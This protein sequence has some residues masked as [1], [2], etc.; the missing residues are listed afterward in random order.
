MSKW[1]KVAPP[2][3]CWHVHIGTELFTP[4]YWLSSSVASNELC[5]CFNASPNASPR[6]ETWG[7]SAEQHNPSATQ[8]ALTSLCEAL[9]GE[10]SIVPQH[11]ECDGI[12]HLQ[13]CTG[14]HLL[15]NPVKQY[16]LDTRPKCINLKKLTLGGNHSHVNCILT[17][18]P[19][20]CQNGWIVIINLD[21]M[22]WELCT[23]WR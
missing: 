8:N 14:L 6:Q 2:V 13:T 7:A 18:L 16:L 12:V 15:Y 11:Y 1:L 22:G 20:A 9:R 21:L 17:I 19:K 4:S 10:I 23:A 5:Y 3:I